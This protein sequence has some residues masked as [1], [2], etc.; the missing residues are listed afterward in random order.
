MAS[1][2]LSDSATSTTGMTGSSSAS[3]AASVEVWVWV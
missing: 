1:L 2:V 3:E